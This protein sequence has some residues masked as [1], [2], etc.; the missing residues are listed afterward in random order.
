MLL[1]KC[2]VITTNQTMLKKK[3]CVFLSKWVYKK[4]IYYVK[5]CKEKPARK[6]EKVSLESS[7][8]RT[9]ERF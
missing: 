7:I 3:K 1:I 6:A 2:F 8:E 5:G 4:F 9:C